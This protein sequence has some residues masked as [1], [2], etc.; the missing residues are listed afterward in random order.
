MFAQEN[1]ESD[2]AEIQ[3]LYSKPA[4]SVYVFLQSIFPTDTYQHSTKELVK[5]ELCARNLHNMDPKQLQEH[6]DTHFSDAP[7]GMPLPV[8]RKV[9]L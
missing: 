8:S 3:F 2:D 5:C 9:L 1:D 6:Y 4:P 7:N